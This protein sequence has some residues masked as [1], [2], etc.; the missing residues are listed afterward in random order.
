MSK[1]K[2]DISQ[3][4][5][6]LEGKLDDRAMHELER[7]ALD[8]PFL[9]DALEGYAAS[10]DQ[11]KNLADLSAR[12]QERTEVKVKR[13]IPWRAISIAASIFI[14]LGIGVWIFTKNDQSTKPA[15]LAAS[16]KPD[17]Q[18]QTL[19]APSVAQVNPGN[20]ATDTLR[21]GSLSSKQQLAENIPQQKSL[22]KPGNKNHSSA[23]AVIAEGKNVPS[24]NPPQNA[25]VPTDILKKDLASADV[26][27][28]KPKWKDTVPAN[29]VVVQSMA[30]ARKVA[31]TAPETLLQS[32]AEGVS[33]TPSL[34]KSIKGT[35]F[36][37]GMPITGATVKLAGANFGAV[38]DANG[39]FS[40]HNIPENAT[41]SVGYI[42]YQSKKVN[43][44]NKDSVN[45][46]LD[47]SA[48]SL[49]EVVVANGAGSKKIANEDAHPSTGWQS[50]ND[51]LKKNAISPDGKTGRVRLSFTVGDKGNLSN[52][53]I[54][55]SLS[56]AAEQKAID[57]VKNGP[58][59]IGSSDQ[60]PHEVKVTVK[61][62]Q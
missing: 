39:R 5:K 6:Y 30:S 42:G 61:F 12:L 43:V 20:A 60:L 13:L 28:Y 54:T 37:N 32:K 48:N 34:G 21:A 15:V 29:E 26:S 53:K 35:V 45:I 22:N 52:F 47:P 1:S 2:H 36:A 41:V 8:D 23:N 11:Q 33:A 19:S 58:D 49:A 3:I 50:F 25:Q 46:D 59:W 16:V 55:K 9:A 40:L 18:S 7:R 14:A 62:H 57:L 24:G 17:T 38:T 44:G 51:Y 10:G 27:Q 31:K 4:K 56:T